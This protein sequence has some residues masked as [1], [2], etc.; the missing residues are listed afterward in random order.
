V[1]GWA[2]SCPPPAPNHEAV[3]IWSP[4]GQPTLTD[5]QAAAYA[6]ALARE[7]GPG[8]ERAAIPAAARASTRSG[9]TGHLVPVADPPAAIF[10]LAGHGQPG[11]AAQRRAPRPKE[12][13]AAAAG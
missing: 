4:P 1:R 2:V 5:A 11:E 7:C 3:D 8:A 13:A 12:R 9:A 6:D 10:R